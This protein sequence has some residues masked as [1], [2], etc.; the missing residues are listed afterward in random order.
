MTE[1]FI[2][3]YMDDDSDLTDEE[4]RA[5]QD[6][7]A[8][9][10]SDEKAPKKLTAEDL[11]NATRMFIIGDYQSIIIGIADDAD[12]D[13]FTIYNP[14]GYDEDLECLTYKP[15]PRMAFDQPL[16]ISRSLVS[17]VYFPDNDILGRY[18]KDIT[19]AKIN[20]QPVS[21]DD[22]DSAMVATTTKQ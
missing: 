20:A 19:T 9:M 17:A 3:D 13:F 10:A 2:D 5:K 8:D 11:L 7:M 22:I 4:I 1:Q 12:P 21:V 14:R 6:A 18:F 15:M 16:N